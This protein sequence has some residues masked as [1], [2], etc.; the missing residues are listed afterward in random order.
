MSDDMTFARRL[1]DLRRQKNVSQRTLAEQVGIDVTYLSK[2]ENDRMAPPSIE[3]IAALATALDAD[4]D[5]L[6]VLAGKIPPDIAEV[7]SKDLDAVKLFRRVAGDLQSKSDW[8]MHLKRN[9]RK[10]SDDSPKQ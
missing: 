9:A 8:S 3:T 2:L 4:V 6:S 1:R 10:K 7:L 5:E